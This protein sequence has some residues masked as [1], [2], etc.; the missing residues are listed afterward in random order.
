M[1]SE[2]LDMPLETDP[3][4]NCFIGRPVERAMIAVFADRAY[5][6]LLAGWIGRAGTLNVVQ[7]VVVFALDAETSEAAEALGV[8]YAFAGPVADLA[9]LW[10]LRARIFATLACRGM[11]FVHSDADALWLA[12]PRPRIS[13]LTS[14]LVFSQGTVWPSDVAR[15]WGFVLCCGFFMH[16]QPLRLPHSLVLSLL[17]LMRNPMT[18]L[19]STGSCK[20]RGSYGIVLRRNLSD[21]A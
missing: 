8:T 11:G 12:E 4:L 16:A 9:A 17:G 1:T 7:D 6:P 20:P 19:L 2:P 21:A 3:A 13:A 14:D 15:A 18:R 5:L 10:R